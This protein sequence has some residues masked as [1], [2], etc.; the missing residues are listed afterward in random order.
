MSLLS[1]L[2]NWIKRQ[3]PKFAFLH[4]HFGDRPFV[5][6]DIGAG[7]S[8]ASKTTNL[9]PQCT[10]YGLDLHKDYNNNNSDFV[11]MK[12]FFEM[13]LTKL[14]FDSI[15]NNF[16][17]A[18]LIVHVIE[19]LH[20]GTDVLKGM[21]PK[22]KPGG[23]LYVEYPGPRSLKLPHMKG[24]LNFND[25]PTH[26]RLYSVRELK[27]VFEEVGATVLKGGTRRSWFYLLATPARIILRMLRG[28]PITGNVFWDLL[29]FAE[30]VEVRSGK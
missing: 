1:P 16:F 11:C 30:Y 17:D 10:Y 27:V 3:N 6:L 13:N 2:V 4:S 8:S 5:L 15:P 23:V 21:L 14:E 7:N 24:S 20:N 26:V 9:F 29:G 19:H 22:L 25:D 12:G 18:I 28:K